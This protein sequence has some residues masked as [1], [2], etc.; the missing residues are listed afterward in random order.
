MVVDCYTTVISYPTDLF[1]EMDSEIAS[2]F[3]A[4]TERG[5]RFLFSAYATCILTTCNVIY[6]LV[7]TLPSTADQALA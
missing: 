5:Q 3:G 4:M 6:P 7:T 1:T 2:G